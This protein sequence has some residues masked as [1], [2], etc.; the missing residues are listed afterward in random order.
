MFQTNACLRPKQNNVPFIHT[1]H[2]LAFHVTHMHTHDAFHVNKI[3]VS[4]CTVKIYSYI[5]EQQNLIQ[6]SLYFH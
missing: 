5:T 2:N 1:T 4:G 6:Y 3:I